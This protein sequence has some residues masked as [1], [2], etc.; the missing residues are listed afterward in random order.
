VIR[1][2]KH[3]PTSGIFGKGVSPKTTG[4]CDKLFR[5]AVS[6]EEEPS[7]DSSSELLPEEQLATGSLSSGSKGLTILSRRN[8]N[9]AAGTRL[10]NWEDM[11]P[12]TGNDALTLPAGTP[13]RPNDIGAPLPLPQPRVCERSAAKRAV[14]SF[15]SPSS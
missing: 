6:T 12:F 7:D 3:H 1:F 8:G 10:F 4:D 9:D 2:R 13:R 5:L 11:L 15:F 14:A